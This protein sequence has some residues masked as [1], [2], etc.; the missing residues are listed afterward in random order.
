LFPIHVRNITKRYGRLTALRDVSFAIWPGEILGL[1][2]P[3]GSGKTTLFECLAGVLPFDAGST[4]QGDEALAPRARAEQ[5]FYLPDGVAP[6]PSES[7][8]WMLDYTLGF[9]GGRA[10]RRADVV[11]RF[12]LAPILNAPLGSLSKGQ[13][14]RALLAMGILTPQPLLLADEPFD[15]LDLRQT[16]E[17]G[18]ALREHAAAGRTLFL[19]IHQISDAARICDRFILLSSGRVCGEGTPDDLAAAAA[20]RAPSAGVSGRSLEE[21]FLALT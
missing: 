2:G 15:G 7:V 20:A 12:D 8:G 3:N 1:I 21:V 5:L 10:D 19:S 4:H 17:V 9:F 18:A 13:R 16:R 14:K 11:R 6:W